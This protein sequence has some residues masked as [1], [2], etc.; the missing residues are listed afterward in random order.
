MGRDEIEDMKRIM[1][2]ESFNESK[3]LGGWELGYY[4][5][6][7]LKMDCAIDGVLEMNIMRYNKN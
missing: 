2:G 7:F 1:D 6:E 4:N 3:A 5:G